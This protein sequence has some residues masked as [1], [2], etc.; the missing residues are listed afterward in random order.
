MAVKVVTDSTSDIPIDT[1]REHGVTVVP[2]TVHFGGQSFRDGVDIDS[3][4]FF[5]RLTASTDLPHTAQPAPS[6]FLEVYQRLLAEGHQ[7]ISVHV[8]S[9]LSGTYNSALLARTDSGAPQ[10]IT[11]VDSGW[12]SMCLGIPVLHAARAAQRGASPAEVETELYDALHRVDL[13]LFVDTLEYLQKGGRIGAARAFVGGLLSVKPLITLRNG[14]V[15][16]IGQVR[17][18]AKAIERVTQWVE[19]HPTVTE[20]SVLHAHSAPDAHR[21]LEHLRARFPLAE[22][23]ITEVGPVVATHVGPGAIGVALLT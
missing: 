19:E 4:T 12:T 5:S 21:L 8:S 13:L 14:E 6:A 20:F 11:V 1:A 18:R 3:A 9:K 7:I 23:H 16:P 2:L 15:A 22:A 10:R 17:Q